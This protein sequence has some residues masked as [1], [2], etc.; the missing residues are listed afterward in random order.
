MLIRFLKRFYDATNPES[1]SRYVITSSYFSEVFKI[2]DTLATWL[3]SKDCSLPVVVVKI[4]EKFDK[5]WRNV[6]KINMMLLIAIFLDP[7]YKSRYVRLC[8]AD[9][10]S[11]ER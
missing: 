10:E 4:K 11:L 2:K 8:Y 7:R 3:K 5:Y 6:D 1:G 9:I